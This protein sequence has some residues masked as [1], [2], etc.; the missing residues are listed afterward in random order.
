M[1]MVAEVAA[2][3]LKLDP[4]ALPSV[5]LFV[6]ATL[7]LTAWE[8]GLNRF[9]DQAKLKAHHAEKVN[10]ALLVNGR[11]AQAAKIDWRPILN[12]RS[13]LPGRI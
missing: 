5:A 9:Y 1:T 11:V 8:A 4:H 2:A 12:A 7:C 3:K 13:F 6:D 10:H